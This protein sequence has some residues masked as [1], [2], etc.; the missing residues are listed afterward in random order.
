MSFCVAF[1]AKTALHFCQF[2]NFPM[3][4][5]I[6]LKRRFFVFVLSRRLGKGLRG[7]EGGKLSF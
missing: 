3:T 2:G 4:T 6:A 1:H 7:V 5:A